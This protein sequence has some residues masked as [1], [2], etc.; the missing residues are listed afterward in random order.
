MEHP[1][2]PSE[3]TNVEWRIREPLLPLPARHGRPRKYSWRALLKALFYVLRTGCQGR[4][5]PPELPQWKTAYPY[6]GSWR[7]FGLGEP[8]NPRLRAQ[9]RVAL[10]R[11]A[12]PSAGSLDRQRGKRTGV[13]G[14]RG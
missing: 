9:G 6:W 5:V 2:Y 3:L 13:G 8:L 7:K 12:H 14:A 4:A 11:E 1:P 10:R